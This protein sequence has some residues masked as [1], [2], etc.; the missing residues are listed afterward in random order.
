MT[1]SDC[2]EVDQRQERCF[3]VIIDDVFANKIN[4]ET[5]E[6]MESIS[7]FPNRMKLR[8]SQGNF[9][10]RSAQNPFIFIMAI[11][12]MVFPTCVA[13]QRV[14]RLALENHAWA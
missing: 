3:E 9:G 12:V 6:S 13:M 14:V 7:I 10:L 11:F 4:Q 1:I 8:L 5:G 2:L